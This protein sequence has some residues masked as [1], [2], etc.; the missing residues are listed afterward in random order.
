[1]RGGCTIVCVMWTRESRLAER[2]FR[3]RKTPRFSTSSL[4][5]RAH[6]AI[7]AL[8]AAAAPDYAHIQALVAIGGPE[9]LHAL[10][11]LLAKEATWATLIRPLGED[12]IPLLQRH[13]PHGLRG[14][15]DSA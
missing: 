2:L 14:P 11:V 5:S 9:A 1:M 13:A 7:P 3:G 6:A 15:F 4:G 12:A 8:M 10:D